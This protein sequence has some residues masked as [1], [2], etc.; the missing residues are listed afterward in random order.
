[1]S[2]KTDF[3]YLHGFSEN[4]QS[5][6]RQQAEFAEFSVYQD[7]DFT[8]TKKLLEV[9]CGVGAQS[10]IILRRFPHLKLT[11][12]DASEKQLGTAQKFL[13]SMDWLK[14]RWNLMAMDAQK[15]SFK[16]NEFDGAFLCW[17]LE[18][19]PDPKKVLNEVK[20]VLTPGSPVYITEVL[21]SSFFLDPYSPYTW[22]Y[23][24]AFNDYQHENAGDPFIGAKLGNILVDLKF[25]DIQIQVKTWYLDKRTPEKRKATI[26]YWT[27]LLMSAKDHLLENKKIDETLVKEMQRELKEIA[28][29]PD[30]VFFYSFIQAKAKV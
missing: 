5:R 4:E 15:M 12:I 19:V 27:D 9:G 22:K 2:K 6:L 21:N 28:N 29:N 3:P 18:H 26:L 1:M 7:V 8:A 20:R 23:W 10:E 24:T 13:K 11:G 30:A 25:T 16:E 14:G 17:I